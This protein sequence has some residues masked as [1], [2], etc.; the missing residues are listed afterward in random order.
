MDIAVGG[1]TETVSMDRLK[2]HTAKKEAQVEM[3][4][5]RGW[6]PSKA[7]GSSCPVA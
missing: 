6:P 3:P 7:S 1:R 2:P 4:P 5:M